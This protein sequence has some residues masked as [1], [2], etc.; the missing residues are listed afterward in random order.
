[1]KADEKVGNDNIMSIRSFIVLVDE[2]D[3]TNG[4]ECIILVRMYP[5]KTNIDD[6]LL[7]VL[8]DARLEGG[9]SA[10]TP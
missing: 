10:M 8:V 6:E 9:T 7:L 1:M 5:H 3:I 4:L 2:I